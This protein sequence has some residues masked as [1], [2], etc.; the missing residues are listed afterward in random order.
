MTPSMRR[1]AAANTALSAIAD[2]EDLL[3]EP[4]VGDRKF[5]RALLAYRGCS[6][7]MKAAVD[8]AVK[9]WCEQFAQLQ[10]E[11][12]WHVHAMLQTGECERAY[13]LEARLDHMATRAFGS[14][15]ASRAFTGISL[16]TPAAYFACLR[17]VCM[18]CG[19]S[20]DQMPSFDDS[21]RPE[22]APCYCIAHD[23]CQRK[24]MVCVPVAKRPRRTVIIHRAGPAASPQDEMAAVF[25]FSESTPELSRS[26]VLPRLSAWYRSRVP[27]A[28]RRDAPILVW[29]K[30]HPLVRERDTLYGALGITPDLAEAAMA[31]REKVAREQREAIDE[32]RRALARKTE[33]LSSIYEAE[34]R[35]WLG[36]GRTR[37]RTIEQ[38]DAC[39]ADMLS[40]A[41]VDRVLNPGQR[42]RRFMDASVATVC[43]SLLL[44]SRALDLVKKPL[45]PAVFD[46][47]VGCATVSCVFGE[48]AYDLQF[49]DSGRLDE[50]VHNEALVAAAALDVVE[51]MRGSSVRGSSVRCRSVRRIAAGDLSREEW[52]EFFMDF[53]LG[54]ISASTVI[55][56]TR[57]A[58][59]KLK[60]NAAS[61]MPQDSPS[62]SWLPPIPQEREEEQE[63]RFAAYFNQMLAACLL[64]EA[65]M[66]RSVMLRQ[67]LPAD[68]RLVLEIASS[69]RF[70]SDTPPVLPDC[71]SVQ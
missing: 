58:A 67:I 23:Q 71:E 19:Q 35:L 20:L 46:W 49:V 16:A 2:M 38:L 1:P 41:G 59:C 26:T 50:A 56:M 25:H 27:D 10:H 33:E 53:S 37:W 3:I 29:L 24:H 14:T 30:A 55:R 8:C 32:R 60:Y 31:R 63:M 21:E 40:S 28:Q 52:F 39:H 62:R 54:A 6:R 68:Q 69:C 51:N 22:I 7:R 11:H 5:A 70:V 44:T 15:V 42:T 47:L 13:E 61:A 66:A 17:G 4:I 64:P 65:G 18:L 36:K 12:V 57:A 43:N 45:S 34:L 9:R 48:P